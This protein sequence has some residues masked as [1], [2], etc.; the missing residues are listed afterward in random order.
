MK[1]KRCREL[2]KGKFG[3]IY[4]TKDKHPVPWIGFK[5]WIKRVPLNTFLIRP[6]FHACIQLGPML[7]SRTNGGFTIVVRHTRLGYAN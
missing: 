6:R 2:L 7:F 4:L 1:E 5:C 3:S